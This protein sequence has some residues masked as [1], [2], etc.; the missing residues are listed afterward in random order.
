MFGEKL[1]FGGANPKTEFFVMG[2]FQ[3]IVMF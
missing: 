1:A 3:Q 2:W